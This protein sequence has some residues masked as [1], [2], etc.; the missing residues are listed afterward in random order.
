MLSEIITLFINFEVIIESQPD[1]RLCLEVEVDFA[2][3]LEISFN[4]FTQSTLS[5]ALTHLAM[6]NSMGLLGQKTCFQVDWYS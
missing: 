4:D 3:G 2:N 6:S 1:V 5:A